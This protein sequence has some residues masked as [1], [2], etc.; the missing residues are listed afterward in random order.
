MWKTIRRNMPTKLTSLALALFLWLI[1]A[2]QR[3]VVKQIQVPLVLPALPDTLVYLNDPPRVVQVTFS[4]SARL[5][6]W[7]RLRPPRLIVPQFPMTESG[8]PVSIPLRKEFL[9]LPR[10]FE[11]EVLDIRP[12]YISLQMAEILEVEVPVFV[13]IGREP[14]H[15]YRLIDTEIPSDPP[16]VIARGPRELVQH[17]NYVRTEPLNL[18]E[19][20]E[21]GTEVLALE[22]SGTQITF[23]P[24]R[25]KVEYHI[26]E[27]QPE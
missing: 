5:L 7:F 26:R 1:V 20:R 4:S 17:R 12:P 6:F 11:G 14:R 19:E 9:D 21:S 2:G 24:D 10:Q 18:T 15:P 8:E 27:W 23:D 16:T 3:D 13:V 22:I 25:V